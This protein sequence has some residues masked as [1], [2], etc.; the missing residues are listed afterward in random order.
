MSKNIPKNNTRKK[1]HFP[2]EIVIQCKKVDSAV[3]VRDST[4]AL[5]R[6]YHIPE[7]K[8]TVMVETES[9]LEIFRRHLLPGTFGR[10]ITS[11][12]LESLFM[13]GSRIVGV[14]SCLTGFWE[15][16]QKPL[17]SLLGLIKQGF[18]E[19][20]KAGAYLWGIM[21]LDSGKSK[22]SLKP[23]IT[24]G[25]K[26]ISSVFWGCILSPLE[27]RCS[28]ISDVEK[29]I[30]YF[31]EYGA[32]VRLGMVGVTSCMAN[33]LDSAEIQRI[34]KIYP[35]FARIKRTATGEK[36]QLCDL[37]KAKSE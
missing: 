9:Q 24:T 6:A 27:M 1:E 37:R 14:G 8:I 2:Y 22:S 11:Q 36:L 30:L 17:S 5:L 18:W 32:L 31:R 26:R 21:D 16:G 25:L 10:L 4:L 12:P 34:A 15:Q 19:C 13:P 3:Q 29:S 28:G 23:V 35:D 7:L 33:L 20:E